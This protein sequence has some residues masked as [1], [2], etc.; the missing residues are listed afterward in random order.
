MFMF[1]VFLYCSF[2]LVVIMVSMMASSEVN[3]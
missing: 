1:D 3:L 2:A